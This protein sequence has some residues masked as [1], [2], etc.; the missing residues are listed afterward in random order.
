MFI[1][2]MVVILSIIIVSMLNYN[3]TPQPKSSYKEFYRQNISNKKVDVDEQVD[4]ETWRKARQILNSYDI[5]NTTQSEL[6]NVIDK[7]ATLDDENLSSDVKE[8]PLEQI[9]SALLDYKAQLNKKN[10]NSKGTTSS[11]QVLSSDLTNQEI[12]RA[13]KIANGGIEE[14]ED[15]IIWEENNGRGYPISEKDEKALGWLAMGA[16]YLL[17]EKFFGNKKS[18]KYDPINEGL[19]YDRYYSEYYIEPGEEDL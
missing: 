17:G 9:R 6:Y 4:N 1:L 13:E 19:K 15:V 11:R 10:L 3:D 16:G 8:F 12:D 14:N 2:L 18:K 5:S 7:L